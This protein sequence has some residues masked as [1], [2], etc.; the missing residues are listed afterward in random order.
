MGNDN[1][2]QIDPNSMGGETNT[3]LSHKQQMIKETLS[4]KLH[5][6][7]TNGCLSYDKFN[8]VLNILEMYNVIMLRNT[9]LSRRIFDMFD[10]NRTDRVAVNQ[11]DDLVHNL[12]SKDNMWAIECKFNR[13]I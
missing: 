10:Y 2:K 9:P 1:T 12:I 3:G 6:E 8:N 4:N 13:L 11:I 7:A 5:Q